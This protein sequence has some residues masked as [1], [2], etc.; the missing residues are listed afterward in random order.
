MIRL[1][2]VT[3]SGQPL[4]F[5]LIVWPERAGPVDMISTA[6]DGQLDAALRGILTARRAAKKAAR[7]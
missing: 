5:T 3:K 6:P 1:D 4:P 7:L 2:Y